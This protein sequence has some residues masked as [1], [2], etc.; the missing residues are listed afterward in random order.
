MK[1]KLSDQ[2]QGALMMALQKCLM[3]QEDIVPILGG[4]VL[5]ADGEGNLFVENPPTFEM[6]SED[7]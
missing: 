7:A 5:V 1:M 4:L 3:E 6:I 2:A